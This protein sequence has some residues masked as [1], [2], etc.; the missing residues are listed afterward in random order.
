MTTKTITKPQL[1]HRRGRKVFRKLG[2]CSQTFEYILNRE[3]DAPRIQEERAVDPLAG[4]IYQLG[5]QCGMLWGASLAVGAEA[6]RRTKDVDRAIP[7]AIIATQAIMKSFFKQEECLDCRDITHCDFTNKWSFFK[8]M[9]SGRFLHCF[10]MAEKWAPE[11]IRT[12]RETLDKYG[13]MK[14]KPS[15][16]CASE[17]AK[18]MG[19]S[20]EQTV[21]VAGFAGGMGLSGN[22]CG[23]LSAAIWL[24]TLDWCKE[25]EEAQSFKNPN[26]EEVLK[27]FQNTMEHKIACVEISE[28]RFNSIQE[29]SKFIEEGG[30]SSLID[31]LSIS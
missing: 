19:A 7:L 2:T 3:F 16:S 9:I 5:H 4:G 11:A 31:L 20:D 24:R 8:Y 28:R 18:K 13:E 1:D 25:N 22:A 14:F 23:A 17:V 27:L 30:C 21:M 29:H 6:Y 15:L 26:A 10:N 12:A